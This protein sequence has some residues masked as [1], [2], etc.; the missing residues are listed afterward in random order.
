MMYRILTL[1]TTGKKRL[2]FVV[3]DAWSISRS[4]QM[5]IAWNGTL[6]RVIVPYAEADG[7][8]WCLE[9]RGSEFSRE[10]GGHQPL[11]LNTP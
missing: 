9:Y 11:K 1:L 5:L 4:I 7:V 2:D 10:S 8:R 3:E 6:Q